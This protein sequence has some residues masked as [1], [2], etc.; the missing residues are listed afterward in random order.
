M[1]MPMVR[2]AGHS[3]PTVAS[4]YWLACAPLARCM[5]SRCL[6]AAV[7]RWICASRGEAG[8]TGVV[9]S[10][11]GLLTGAAGEGGFAG[12]AGQFVR[13]GL[14]RFGVD[15]PTELRFTC[16]DTARPL[17]AQGPCAQRAR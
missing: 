8:T 16:T 11:L 17:L 2:L 6:S 15:I 5:A 10:V 1:V 13:R 12:L 14:M 9:A 4:A 7:L 3:C